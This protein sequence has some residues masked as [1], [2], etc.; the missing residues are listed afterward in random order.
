MTG[1]PAALLT[2]PPRIRA[3]S[4]TERAALGY[5]HA[6][7]GHC[8]ASDGKL[9]NVGIFLRHMTG[10]PVE[11]ALATTVDQPVRDPAPGQTADAVMRVEPGHPERSVLV[12]RMASRWAALQM[13][14]LGTDLADEQ[15]LDLV[16][17]WIT[18]IDAL[19]TQT[20]QGGTRQ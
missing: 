11:A 9:Q 14:P 12:Q 2:H 18:E 13:P 4:P 8:H 17:K 15:A 6:N 10:D 19:P 5:L 20:Q 3:T 16:R 1:L 7:C